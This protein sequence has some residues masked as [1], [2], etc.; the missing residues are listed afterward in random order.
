MTTVGKRP[1]GEGGFTLIELMIAAA[2]LGLVMAGL[3]SVLSGSQR[4]YTRGS[5]TS[6]AQQTVRTAIERIAKE[7]R[8]AGYHPQT[9]DTAPLT[10]PPGAGGL[11][12]SGGGSAAPCWSFYPIIGQSATGM[13]LQYDWNS[14]GIITA[15]KVN[16]ALLCP[17]PAATCRGEQVVYALAGQNLTRQEIGVDAAAVTLASGVTSLAFTYLDANNAVTASRDLIRSVRISVTA[18]V[19]TDGSSASMTDQIRLRNR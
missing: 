5:N 10:C 15:A 2:V 3:L 6:D 12:P 19:G 7:I 14:S 1:R 9:P 8:E 17:P 4:A 16:D 18:Q 13:T 11:Y